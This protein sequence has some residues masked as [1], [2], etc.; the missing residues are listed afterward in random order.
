MA[1]FIWTSNVGSSVAFGATGIKPEF[2]PV[3]P[4]TVLSCSVH[5]CGYSGKYIHLYQS[6]RGAYLCKR[7]LGDCV[8]LASVDEQDVVSLLSCDLVG[9]EDGLFRVS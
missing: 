4:F 9:S 6:A 2:A 8:V 1:S 7:G 5:G 3:S